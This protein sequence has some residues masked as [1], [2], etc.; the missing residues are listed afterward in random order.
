MN[1][2]AEALVKAE[3]KSAA[4]AFSPSGLSLDDAAH[5]YHQASLTEIRQAALMA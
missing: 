3:G 5:L 4:A 2:L 1:G